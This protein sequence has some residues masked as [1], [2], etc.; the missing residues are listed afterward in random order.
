MIIGERDQ[1]FPLCGNVNNG[2]V[3][4]V[5]IARSVTQCFPPVPELPASGVHLSWHMLRVIGC[6]LTILLFMIF[7][8]VFFFFFCLAPVYRSSLNDDCV[9][10]ERMTRT[11]E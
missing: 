3:A 1:V 9:V 8:R 6:H 10:C 2:L 11:Q 5:G 7:L 4:I